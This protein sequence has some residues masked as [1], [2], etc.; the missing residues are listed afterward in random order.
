MYRSSRWRLGRRPC[1]DSLKGRSFAK[2]FGQNLEATR[3]ESGLFKQE[4][5]DAAGLRLS[6]Y[7]SYEIGR[8]PPLRIL[9]RIAHALG[10]EPAKLLPEMP[11]GKAQ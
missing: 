7:R 4:A 1:F 8:V 9:L 2:A 11:A 10:V 6:Q 5:A 3:R